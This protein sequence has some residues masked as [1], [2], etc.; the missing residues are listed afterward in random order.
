MARKIKYGSKVAWMKDYV[1]SAK[2]LVDLSRLTEIQGYQVPLDKEPTSSASILRNQG[3]W[4][5]IMIRLTKP[6][7]DNLGNGKFK[8]I[9]HLPEDL[10]FLLDSLAHELAHL[11]YWEHTPSHLK[12]QA[13]ILVKFAEVAERK[14]VKDTY[15]KQN[16]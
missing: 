9:A 11:E 12:L 14:E 16:T 2:G 8:A 15:G 4:F 6:Q 13:Q 5:K 7:F 3:N 10:A 1:Q